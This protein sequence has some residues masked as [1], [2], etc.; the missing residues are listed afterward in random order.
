MSSTLVVLLTR[1]V[2]KEY[3]SHMEEKRIARNLRL[4][5]KLN[6]WVT[7]ESQRRGISINALITIALEL[8]EMRSRE[9][10]TYYGVR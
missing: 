2:Q 1:V 3:N 7:K 5:R 6:K 4:P 9:D 8:Y 10:S